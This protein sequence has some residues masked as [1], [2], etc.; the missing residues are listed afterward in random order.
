MQ[1]HEKILIHELVC[2]ALEGSIC[3][4][5]SDR[6]Q[7]ILASDAGA[8]RYYQICI[9]FNLGLQKI[10]PILSDSWAMS[11][12]LEE[13]AEYEK[14]AEI[15]NIEEVCP[16][17]DWIPVEMTP[18]PAAVRR[19]SKMLLYT[20]IA[21]TAALLLMMLYVYHNPRPV[22]QE[23]ATLMDSFNADWAS[24]D[25][26]L[27]RGAR[28]M[29]G[30]GPIALN[31]GMIKLL[32]D[33]GVEVVIEA[34][35][36]FE[37]LT[38][39]E[40]TLHHGRLFAT[41][42]DA[43]KGFIVRTQNAR[44]I[45]LGTEF[46]VQTD[47][48]GD[49]ALHVFKGKTALI[50]GFERKGKEIVE[51]TAQQARRVD[52]LNAEIKAIDL[53]KS[54]FAR[55]F[56]SEQGTVW[57]GEYFVSL[58]D[59]LSGTLHVTGGR[60]ARSV[61]EPVWVKSDKPELG[62]GIFQPMKNNLFINGIFVPNG[63]DGPIAISSEADLRWDAPASPV[64]QRISFLRFDIRSFEGDAG[65]A[66]LRMNVREMVGEAKPIAVY[67]LVRE[68]LDDWSE[69]AL[70][71]ANAP[72]LLAAPLG[73]YNLDLTVLQRLGTIAFKRSGMNDSE[74]AKL[75]M[76][77]FIRRDTNGLVTLVLVCEES[78][79]S[80]EWRFVSK[81]GDPSTAPALVFNASGPEPIKITTADGNGADTYAAHDNHHDVITTEN[82]YGGETGFRVRNYWKEM[83][84]ITNSGVV[85]FDEGGRRERCDFVL[86]GRSAG[87][88]ENPV[89]SL[90]ANAGITFDLRQMRRQAPENRSARRFTAMCG[91]PENI[92]QYSTVY[93]SGY[94][95]SVNVYILV[96][97]QV[98]F[99][100]TDVNPLQS[101]ESIDLP[102]SPADRYLTLTVTSAT[103]QKTSFDWC[104]FVRPQIMFE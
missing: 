96:D 66:I 25:S 48:A 78:E 29:T 40:I 51:V 53:D 37:L 79:L 57:R 20:A 82:V 26:S 89:V 72:G 54:A 30:Q 104:L 18:V 60:D 9:Q 2:K 62:P 12:C 93:R 45:D 32:Y 49:T 94:V 77:E 103:E 97:G 33:D 52:A 24:P 75:N 90:R 22:Q 4:S 99:V 101:A 65:G 83:I 13:M 67:G 95:P 46:G 34:P 63:V 71:Y 23:V 42:S 50:A 91:V 70:N 39:M 87:A 76:D 11:L 38:S 74:P 14:T 58:S 44:I 27:K 88:G 3:D 59:A 28:V 15:L 7:E 1:V 8:L 81:E 100:R 16:K 6:L 68:E 21:S 47:S 41:V 92:A 98:R 86:E 61:A 17:P 84:L 102:L 64:R 43:G 69:A 56:D 19:K 80:A 10:Q 36:K 31:R 73:R 55:S 5:E 35:A 85:E